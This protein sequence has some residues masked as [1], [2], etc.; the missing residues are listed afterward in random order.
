MLERSKDIFDWTSMSQSCEV[1]VFRL[2]T[3]L[4]ALALPTVERVIQ[5]QAITPL[6]GAP[7]GVLGVI[8]VHGRLVPILDIRGRF[9]LSA[10][11][12]RLSDQ[13]ILAHTK[14][15]LVGI[16]VDAVEVTV[17][18]RVEEMVAAEVLVP[19]L[20][21]LSGVV[22][23]RDGLTLI[24]DLDAFLSQGEAQVLDSALDGLA[25]A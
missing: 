11:P 9:G 14:Q 18:Y 13:I 5:A 24:H 3:L 12:L 4:N 22:Q 10:R 19:G 16:C 6:L 25:C 20:V 8:D 15:R 7:S 17:S 2:D 23:L 1:V 21:H